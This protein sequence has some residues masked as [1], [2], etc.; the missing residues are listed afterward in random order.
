MLTYT[1]SRREKALILVFV[2]ILLALVWYL[3][4]FQ[5]T[6]AQ[7]TE[8]DSQINTVQTETTIASAQVSKMHVMQKAIEESKA[9][10]AK[11]TPVPAY[12]NMS[13]L[14]TEL[15]AIMGTTSNYTLSFDELD[16][17]TSAG[18]VLRGV[19]ADFS[20]ASFAEA[21]RVIVALA[22]GAYP[23]SIDSVNV[24]EGKSGSSTRG[25]GRTGTVTA[26]MH[27]TFFERA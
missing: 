9:R 8:M 26:S 7:I 24:V 3:F 17:T 19:R 4:V 16:T 10:G 15:N 20:C 5:R 25:N 11:A 14:M 22:D 2:I 12:D 27:V 1:F 13:P 18:Y 21:E 23:C 6:A